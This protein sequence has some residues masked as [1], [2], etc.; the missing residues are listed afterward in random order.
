MKR[1]WLAFPLILLCSL[2]YSGGAYAATINAA[3]CS[4]ANVQSA[5]NSASNGDVVTVPAGNC[6][7]TSRVTISGKSITLQGAGVAQTNITDSAGGALAINGDATH[8]VRVTGFTFIHNSTVG[9]CG[10]VAFNAVGTDLKGTDPPVSFRLD[11]VRFSVPSSPGSEHILFI[12]TTYG[13]I[14]HV[15]W[16]IP[17]TASTQALTIVGTQESQDSGFRA[18]QRPQSLGTNKA[19]YLEDS[20]INYPN[21]ASEDAVDAYD[22]AR[23]VLR[24][25]TFNGKGVGFHGTDS[26]G[27]RSM[28]TAEIYNNTFTNQ[29]GYSV[30]YRGGSGVVFNNTGMGGIEIITYRKCSPPLDGWSMGPDIPSM[31]SSS[32]YSNS[33]TRDNCGSGTG[34]NVKFCSGNRE[35]LCRV[36]AD[37]ASQGIS[38]TCSTFFDGPGKPGV[39]GYPVRDQ[40][41]TTTGQVSSPLYAWNNNQTIGVTTGGNDA[42]CGANMNADLVSGRDYVNN[43]TTAKPGYTPYTYPHPLQTGDQGP[44][45]PGGLTATAH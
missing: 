25:N 18:W 33:G 30:R 19:V 23:L 15:T 20:T 1:C 11:Q 10:V 14:D 39:N 3:S 7:W 2:L 36:D 38:G 28:H 4:S 45:P 17:A 43:G 26:G 16:D 24:H 29:S 6:T 35:F 9:C 34:C 37:C 41:G 21:G 22:G 5:I 13:L 40:P 32:D 42:Q 31:L 8:F 44:D 27:H 12:E